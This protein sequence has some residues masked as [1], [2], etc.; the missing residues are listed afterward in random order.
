MRFVYVAATEKGEVVRGDVDALTLREAIRSIRAKGLLLTDI[1]PFARRPSLL[2]RLAVRARRVSLMQVVL[3]ARQLALLIRAGI[4]VDRSFEILVNQATKRG[5]KSVLRDVLE[6]IRRGEAL[7]AALRRHPQVFPERFVAVVEWGE[8]GGKL[9]ESLEHLATQLERDREL[10]A[11]VRGAMV[12]PLIIVGAVVIISGLMA[13]FVLPQLVETIESFEV[14]LPIAT[15]IF[16][17]VT[18][19]LTDYG[20]IVFPSAIGGLLVLALLFRTKTLRPFLHRLFLRLPIA[21][22]IVRMVNLARFDRAFGSLI[23]SGI[24]IVEAL[25]IV[26]GILGNVQYQEAIE[27]VTGDV[28]KGVS[29]GKLLKKYGTLF[30]PIETDMIAIGEETGK[31][32]DVLLYLAEYYEGSVDQMTKNLAQTIEPVL[33]IFIGIVVG[34]VVLAVI[35]PIY[36]ISEAIV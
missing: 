17:S 13:V 27:E 7:A 15:R 19:A 16:L 35:M 4:T 18:K 28:R 24:P 25:T 9:P 20:L 1:H 34:G 8:A 6:A 12:Y 26:R 21:G 3:L 10:Q 33:L 2:A 29:V 32:D 31:L 30:P 11:K 36:Q 5:L 14:E 23:Q 22:K